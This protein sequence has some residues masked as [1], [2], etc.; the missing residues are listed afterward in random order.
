MQNSAG[1]AIFEGDLSTWEVGQTSAKTGENREEDAIFGGN[2]CNMTRKEI[3][4]R[5]L[6]FCRGGS[7]LERHDTRTHTHNKRSRIWTSKLL[8]SGPIWV[9]LKIGYIPNYS[10][11]IGIMI[12]NHWVKRGTLFSDTP[13]WSYVVLENL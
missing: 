2:I 6:R 7:P 12:I 1:K 8:N 10:H 11:L 5:H 3:L 13:I 4:R 9:C